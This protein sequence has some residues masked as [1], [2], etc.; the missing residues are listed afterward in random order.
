MLS[1]P[2]RPLWQILASLLRAP[3]AMRLSCDECFAVLEYL[4]EVGA[5]GGRTETIQEAVRQHLAACPSCRQKH[6]QRLQEMEHQLF[7]QT[8]LPKAS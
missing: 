3:D 5:A 6:L 4:A 7:Q 2:I 1:Q 8:I